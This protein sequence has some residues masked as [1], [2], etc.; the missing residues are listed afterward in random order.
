MQSSNG[1]MKI[2]HPYHKSFWN[3]CTSPALSHLTLFTFTELLISRQW[4]NFARGFYM[5]QIQSNY[6]PHKSF[7]CPKG[8]EINLCQRFL[9][10]F[11]ELEC[12]SSGT[13]A[14]LKEAFKYF[15]SIHQNIPPT[16]LAALWKY[17]PWLAWVGNIT[18]NCCLLVALKKKKSHLQMTT[19]GTNFSIIAKITS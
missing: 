13:L 10:G 7:I 16:T 8:N 1:L 12:F 18:T 5:L 6:I 11:K 9:L 15:S 19:D 14:S 4:V 2:L 17:L 3:V